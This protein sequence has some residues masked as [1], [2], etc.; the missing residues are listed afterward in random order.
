[1]DIR[2]FDLQAFIEEFRQAERTDLSNAAD[3]W[4]AEGYKAHLKDPVGIA[5]AYAAAN[6]FIS[7]KKVI[8]KND[9]IA[10]S[11]L[12]MYE[13]R[14]VYSETQWAWAAR[15][16]QSYG[17]S[18]FENNVDHFCAD[19]DRL[20][21]EG[22][23]GR[24]ARIRQAL[25][26]SAGDRS[27]QEFLL[28]AQIALE[29]FCR[30]IEQYAQEAYAMNRRDMGDACMAVVARK[31]ESFREALQLIWLVHNAFLCQGRSA[32]AF[33]RM[34]QYLYPFYKKDREEGRFT[35]EEI[36]CMLENCFYKLKN[37]TVN[38][39]IGGVTDKGTGGVNALSYLI[40]RAVEHCNIPGPNLSARWYEGIPKDFIDACLEVIGTGLGYPAMMNDTVIIPALQAYG[41]SLEDC[42]NYCMVGCIENFIAGKQPAWSDGRFNS[43]KFLELALNQGRDMLSDYQLGPV[44]PPVSDIH[45]MEELLEILKEQLAYGAAL[46]VR[47][48]NNENDRYNRRQYTQPFLSCFCQDC[49]GRGRDI[50][51]GGAVYPSVHGACC[52]GIGT[53]ADSLAAL[54]TVVFQQKRYSLEEV[55]EA[56]LQNFKGY[57]IMR[58]VLLEAPKYG[59]NQAGPDFYAQWFVQVHSQ[60]FAPYRTRDGGYFYIAMAANI[61]NIDAGRQIAATPD[62]RM[63]R[64]PLSDA[65][66]PMHG[67][68]RN[69]PTAVLL[70]VSKPDYTKVA[71]GTVL[72]QK[73]S[74]GLFE[75]RENIEKLRHLIT[76]YFKRGGQEIQINAVSKKILKDA[77]AHPENYGDLVVRVSG[78]SAFFT[79]LSPQV[80]EDILKRTEHEG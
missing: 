34:D 55:R 29:G 23:P 62:G 11:Q 12:G 67:M 14:S 8:L 68:D 80:Q 13:A 21:E 73:Y 31:P 44:T 51:D 58:S 33:G 36:C 22:L 27:K 64:A 60:L 66:S 40:L 6:I 56:L 3:I 79:Q 43:P 30:M 9:I 38:I 5:R 71:C 48:F 26:D 59:N 74:P 65:A 53:M 16:T 15:L 75:S 19:Y 47:E 49:I 32:M 77:M 57:E 7:H 78:F 70:S 28:S 35:D 63:C 10:G 25:E 17:K 41:Y 54:D 46:Y 20:L 69:G 1:M 24:L 18:S 72:N 50:N 76:V 39:V 37:D 52:M 2:G 4:A 45:C 42:R 61:A